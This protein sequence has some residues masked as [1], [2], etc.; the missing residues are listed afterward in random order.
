MPLGSLAGW[1]QA[2]FRNNYTVPVA[3]DHIQVCFKSTPVLFPPCH[4]ISKFQALVKF[5][6][7]QRVYLNEKK[8][9]AILYRIIK[10]LKELESTEFGGGGETPFEIV[11]M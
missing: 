4:V 9:L 7:R 3:K 8:N 10:G 1:I 2:R 6:K 11:R 5:C